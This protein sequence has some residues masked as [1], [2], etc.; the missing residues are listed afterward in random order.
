MQTTADNL[1]TP[2]AAAYFTKN[3]HRIGALRTTLDILGITYP[4][5]AERG[6]PGRKAGGINPL[7]R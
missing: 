5:W 1:N 3:P 6:R 7:G 2:Q 4:A